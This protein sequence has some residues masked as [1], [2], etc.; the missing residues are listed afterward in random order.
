M[1]KGNPPLSEKTAL[2]LSSQLAGFLNT[3]LATTSG[4]DV[5]ADKSTPSQNPEPEPSH[6]S[7]ST[8]ATNLESDSSDNVMADK[9]IDNRTWAERVAAQEDQLAAE[10]SHSHSTQAHPYPGLRGRGQGTFPLNQGHGHGFFG[11]SS[12]WGMAHP[13]HMSTQ[14][15]HSGDTLENNHCQ[16]TDVPQG[17]NLPLCPQWWVRKLS[18]TLSNHPFSTRQKYHQSFWPTIESLLKEQRFH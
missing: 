14:S 2:K 12:I 1:K 3:D 5:M 18:Q 4:L 9:S 8:T 11:A 15:S 17:L 16:D 7:R 13:M 6:I 10:K